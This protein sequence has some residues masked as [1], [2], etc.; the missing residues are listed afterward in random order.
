[1]TGNIGTATA[2]Q[3]ALILA[4]QRADD[5]DGWAGAPDA[6]ILAHVRNT[7]SLPSERVVGAFPVMDD[8]SGYSAALIA[9][10]TPPPSTS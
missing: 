10:L 3:L 4:T 7:L 5:P 6:E 1:M 2:E 9:F 8:G